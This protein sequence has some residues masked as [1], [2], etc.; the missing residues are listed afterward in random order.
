TVISRRKMCISPTDARPLALAEWHETPFAGTLPVC[1]VS[2]FCDQGHFPRSRG[3]G[4]K[5][6]G[7]QVHLCC[8]KDWLFAAGQHSALSCAIWGR[9]PIVPKATK[10]G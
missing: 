8:W 10:W 4:D 6:G 9:R 2:A 3:S 5:A 1:D 7:R